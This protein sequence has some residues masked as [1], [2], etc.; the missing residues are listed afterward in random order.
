MIEENKIGEHPLVTRCMKGIYVRKTPTPKYQS[1]SDVSKVTS[2]L[3]SQGP[4]QD[5]TLK[6]LTLKTYMLC[7]LVCAQ[8]EQTLRLLDLNNKARR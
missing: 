4:L 1:T 3:S 2:Y 8:R 7:S 6:A 5:L